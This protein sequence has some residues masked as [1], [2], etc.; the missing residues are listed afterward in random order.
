MASVQFGWGLPVGAR[1]NRRATFVADVE[2]GLALIRGHFDSAWVIDHLLMGDSDV[3][4][5]WTEL[6]FFAAR[7]PGLRWGHAV[8]SQSF[9]NPALVA[10]MAA[11]LHFLTGGQYILGLGAGWQEPEY[12]AYGYPFPP[13][14]VRVD[15]LEEAVSVVKALWGAPPA[16]FVG[17]YYRVQEALCE[18][19]PDPRP[20]IMI[21]GEKP[22]M[23]RLVARH[24]DWWNVS[25][26][27][28]ADYRAQV[29]EMERACADVGRDPATLRRTWHGGCACAPTAAQAQALATPRFAGG[30]A[31]LGTPAQV[32]EQMQPFVDMGVDYFQLSCAG[33]PDLTSLE[34]LVGEVLPA[35]HR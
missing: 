14:G 11:S 15:E 26:T 20:I 12:R 35:L 18:P 21:G 22:R 24:A 4:E 6:T 34:M 32:I 17:R 9:R 30:N 33:F 1:H 8:L 7:H 31:F 13:A 27:G 19:R 3:L 16:T 29:A 2:R 23:L 5:A 10:K 25:W 28:I